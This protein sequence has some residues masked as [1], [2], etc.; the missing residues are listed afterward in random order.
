MGVTKQKGCANYM[1][2]HLQGHGEMANNFYFIDTV[3]D[4]EFDK[5]YYYVVHQLPNGNRNV[6][7]RYFR[8]YESA[9]QLMEEMNDHLYNEEEQ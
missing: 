9:Q 7:S 8:N 1:N 2:K 4:K 6:V 5:T 3:Y